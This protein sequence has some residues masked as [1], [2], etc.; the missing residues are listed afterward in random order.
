MLTNWGGNSVS[1]RCVAECR[2]PNQLDETKIM[3]PPMIK[4]CEIEL[5]EM[6]L[7]DR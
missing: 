2:I 3:F 5:G 4:D 1:R 6:K 7:L